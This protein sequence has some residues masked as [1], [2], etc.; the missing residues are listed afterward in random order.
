M[1]LDV[2]ISELTLTGGDV[3]DQGGAVRSL[4]TLTLSA[5]VLEA[6]YSD[7]GGG[8]VI[9]SA[10]STSIVESSVRDNV[11]GGSGGGIRADNSVLT[12]TNS[13][14]S[15]NRATSNDSRFG[16][17]VANFG[18]TATIADSTISG[19]YSSIGGGVFSNSSLTVV[20]STVT[21]NSAVDGFGQAGGIRATGN[22]LILDHTIVAGNTD[23]GNTV[24]GTAPDL[25]VEGSPS[26]FLVTFS[27]IGDNTGSTLTGA[28]VGTPDANG[29]LIGDPT[30]DAG[31]IN[32]TLR[33]TFR[34]RRAD[35][36]ARAVA[37]QP[38]D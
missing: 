37:W 21:A 25:E 4:E 29:N 28:P 1:L 32:A 31:V 19:N 26:T 16:G 12:V 6:N 10:G 7:S 22:T 2:G 20:R 14:I 18:G 3:L 13:T 27:L 36:Y 33:A 5:M 9:V 8:A 35:V 34:Q 38:S 30:G 15:G 11:T 23:L 24:F 17:G